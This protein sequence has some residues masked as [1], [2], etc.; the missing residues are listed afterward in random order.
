MRDEK[1]N[2]S[3]NLANAGFDVPL[4][5][6]TNAH[7]FVP[8]NTTGGDI[9]NPMNDIGWHV[10]KLEES[11]FLMLP[12]SHNIG[13]INPYK[14]VDESD[15]EYVFRCVV[16]DPTNSHNKEYFNNTET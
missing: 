9:W 6:D 1:I 4:T 16:I 3:E 12:I 11:K 13:V 10:S 2:V 5:L 15:S 7:L 8:K 14:L